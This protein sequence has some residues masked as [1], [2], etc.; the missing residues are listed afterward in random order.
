MFHFV[1]K[2]LGI[3][4]I[5]LLW[6]A[7]LFAEDHYQTFMTECN[8]TIKQLKEKDFVLTHVSS[9]ESNVNLFFEKDNE[10]Y[11]FRKAY[12]HYG[13]FCYNLTK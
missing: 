8:L 2:L 12:G 11:Q 6:S 10:L 13:Y 3:V 1:K 7:T 5:C 9:D 4:V